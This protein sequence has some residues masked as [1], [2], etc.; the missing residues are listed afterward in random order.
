VAVVVGVVEA[1]G[2]FL[3]VGR[4][5]EWIGG[6][7]GKSFFGVV[8]GYLGGEARGELLVRRVPEV[9]VVVGRGIAVRRQKELWQ[10]EGLRVKL[11]GRHF[12]EGQGQTLLEQEVKMVV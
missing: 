2:R 9:V 8:L 10:G 11:G 12:W 3:E 1:V 7:E 6:V 4:R 5:L